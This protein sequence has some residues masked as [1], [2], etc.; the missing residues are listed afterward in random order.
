VVLGDDDHVYAMGGMNDTGGTSLVE[1]LYTPPCPTMIVNPEPLQPWQGQTVVLSATVG[2]GTPMTY[3]WRAD[4]APL[5]DG[6]APGGGTITGAT[7]SSL[8]ITTPAPEDD[9]SYDLVA[10]NPCGSVT[11]A[12]AVLAVRVPP[13]LPVAWT[14]TNLHPAWALSSGASDTTGSRQTGTARMDTPEYATIQRPV[15]WEGTTASA[16]DLTPPL[17]AGGSAGATAG[18][19]QVGWWW[20]PYQCYIGGQWYT[21]YSRQACAWSST[22]GSY[23]NLQYSGWE[24]SSASDTDGTIHVG[25]I[26]T[27]DAV[28]NTFAHAG[29]WSP[30]SYWFH[31]L[32]PAGVSKS[33]AN[34]IDG[35][36]QYGSINTPY[37][38]PTTHAAMW[39]GTASSFVDVNPP[40]AYRS[41]IT[42]ANDGQQVGM[43]EIAGVLQPGLWSGAAASFQPMTPSFATNASLSACAGGLQ[44]G[45]ASIDSVG[46]AGLWRGAPDEFLDLHAFLPSE[47]VSSSAA[48]IHV[49]E[50]TGDVTVVGSGYNATTARPE[51]LMWRSDP[52]AACVAD[53]DSSGDVGF[54]DI[55]QII[56][57]WGPCSGAC[58]ADLDGSGDVGFADVLAVIGAWGPC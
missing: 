36:H 10:T 48:G 25:T 5:V 58:P 27:D 41:W 57:A 46:R 6:P 12:P 47:F 13:P 54:G 15:L 24:Y 49:D 17:S 8:T 14:V 52:S 44:V 26:S 20:W 32:H 33:F 1:K 28:G 43:A 19:A 39:S 56:G 40:G 2:G 7:T 16:V 45:S 18:D 35:E 37:P 42:G 50:V 55:L 51:A 3:Q 11:S 9:G 23:V 21:C 31:D 22:A 29:Y 30:P 53:I 38:G 34:A 4:G